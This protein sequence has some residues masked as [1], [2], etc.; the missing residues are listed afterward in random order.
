MAESLG[1]DLRPLGNRTTLV[2]GLC[3]GTPGS[4]P[5]LKRVAVKTYLQK[6]VTFINDEEG[7][8]AAEY[9]LLVTL[10]AVVILVGV[11]AL[12]ISLS[13]MYTS[14]AERVASALPE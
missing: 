4:G 2:G 8:S 10:I 5:G 13:E 7:A 12:G 1:I 6:I 3:H 14:N 9:G 11:V